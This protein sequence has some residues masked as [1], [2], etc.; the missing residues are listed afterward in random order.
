MSPDTTTNEKAS[1]E[2]KSW[3]DVVLAVLRQQD[4]SVHLS[5]LYSAVRRAAPELVKGNPDWTNDKIR[6]V[7]QRLGARGLAV[8]PKIGYWGAA[9]G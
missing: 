5:V 8:H 6:Q 7:V 1:A 3:N 4:G 2:S 9:Q